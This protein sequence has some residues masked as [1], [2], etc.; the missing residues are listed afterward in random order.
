MIEYILLGIIQGI[1]EWLP[2]SS[3]AIVALTSD[4]LKIKNPIDVA[5]FLHLGTF[6]SVMIYF[7]ED[8]LKVFGLREK[9]LF[10][11][12]GITTLVSLTVGFF[13]Y[14]IIKDIFIGNFLL[15][16]TGIALLLTSYFH[17]KKMSL[18]L[19]TINLAIFSGFLQGLAAIPGLSRSG[20]TIFG[21]SQSKLKPEQI[22][23]ISY[24]MSAPVILASSTYLFFKNPDLRIAWPALISSFLIGILTLKILMKFSQK[25]NFSKF[26]LVFG[27]LCIIGAGL[28]I[29][30]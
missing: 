18:K 10:Y 26:T 27:I 9:N 20:S 29:L 4:F 6:F 23:R 2:I 19:N 5:I 22:L 3:E 14:Q 28:N 16:S 13:V 12:L 25:F 17:K 15:F 8:W 30:I 24:M 1:F 11:F 21:L 7:R